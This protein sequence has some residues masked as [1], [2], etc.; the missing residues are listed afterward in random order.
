MGAALRIAVIGVGNEY[1]RDDGVGW[2]VVARLAERAGIQPLPE[3]T[4]LAVC[5]GDPA[6]MITLWSGVDLALVVD[7]ARS[8]PPC[9]GRVRR[10]EWNGEQLSHVGGSTS[11]HG[12]G[13]GDAVELSRVLA[14]LPRH[15][16]VYAVEAA[17][18]GLGTGLSAPVAAAV[19]PLAERI[20]QEITLRAAATPEG[21]RDQNPG[22]SRWPTEGAPARGRPGT[23]SD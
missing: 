3:G 4:T 9:P 12:L 14:R 6:R 20:A 21:K 10:M 11:T 16:V 7:A 2:G 1:R 13:L 23:H 15:L 19:E 18:T 17:D 5:D 22:R 8:C